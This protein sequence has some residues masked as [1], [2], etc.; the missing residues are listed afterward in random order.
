MP[1]PGPVFHVIYRGVLWVW[2]TCFST[3]NQPV[4]TALVT[5]P[6]PLGDLSTD[7]GV[8]GGVIPTGP[9][10]VLMRVVFV[11]LHVNRVFVT[12]GPFCYR[13]Y[14]RCA[15]GGVGTPGGLS[16]LPHPE[17]LLLVPLVC[18]WN[19]DGY[20]PKAGELKVEWGAGR[21]LFALR[22]AI[23]FM[24]P[25]WLGCGGDGGS[26]LP[27]PEGP[28]PQRGPEKM[29]MESLPAS[30]IVFSYCTVGT[31]GCFLFWRRGGGL[32]LGLL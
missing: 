11:S 17:G 29:E 15:L 10:E 24:H 23:S 12:Q 2:D 19:R 32:R 28:E 4:V 3:R 30:F 5:E 26:A 27:C 18:V 6:R 7:C 1:P 21:Q 25:C 13:F 20:P 16:K 9:G 8:L 31:V 14:P 22:S